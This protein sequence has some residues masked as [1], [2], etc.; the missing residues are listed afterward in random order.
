MSTPGYTR[1]SSFTLGHAAAI[2]AVSLSLTCISWSVVSHQNRLGHILA[3]QS[4][5]L[6]VLTQKYTDGY[7]CKM[8]TLQNIRGACS[9]LCFADPFLLGR[10]CYGESMLHCAPGRG[11]NESHKVL[12]SIRNRLLGFCKTLS[13]EYK[14]SLSQVELQ[15]ALELLCV[16]S[17]L[18][19]QPHFKIRLSPQ[20][21]RVHP[22]PRA[23]STPLARQPGE[24]GVQPK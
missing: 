3:H 6:K 16:I 7:R 13:Q 2:W 23:G 24:R 17:R 20:S 1:C 19:A 9:K 14:L 11:R 12:F 22:S 21:L 8:E 5:E 15:H 4:L 10:A 18:S